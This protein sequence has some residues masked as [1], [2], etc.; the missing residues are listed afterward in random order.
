MTMKKWLIGSLI[1]LG[2]WTSQTA[3]GQ[4]FNRFLSRIGNVAL[5]QRQSIADSFMH[6]TNPLPYYE[7]DTTVIFLYQGDAQSVSMAGDATGWQPSDSFEKVEGCDLWY[8]KATYEPDARLDYKLV[9]NGSNWILDPGNPKTC[10]SG[11]GENSEL[12]MPGN[13]IPADI[14]EH[15]DIPGG[16]VSDTI[17]HSAFLG[18]SRKVSI[19]LPVGYP[20]GDIR[21]PVVLFHDGPDY[22][23][24][25]KA[26]KILDDLISKKMMAPV[27]AVFVPFVDR[28][29]EYSGK[30]K[31][32]F[33]QFI[34]KELIPALDSRLRLEPDIS[35]R[36]M[37]GASDGGN[38]SL[39]IGVK[40]PGFFGKIAVQ[41]SNVIPE[42]KETIEK[43]ALL[44]L[45]FYLDIG[46]YDIDILIPMAYNLRD[47]LNKKG[48][49]FEFREW[50]EGHSWG[51]WKEH[52]R[53]PLSFFFPY[54]TEKEKSE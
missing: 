13:M 24:I 19:Y 37:I 33:A 21:Y 14:R 32:L 36:A 35:E 43:S 7:N 15:A 49:R 46:K 48:Y 52:L 42:V 17:F 25:C 18:D 28:S 2:F 38:I 1:I 22:L 31:D 51:N 8:Y 23:N 4:N 45:F 44:P 40:Y 27:V 30:R 20:N 29:A 11:F 3:M 54:S 10:P 41:S 5:P 9:I 6:A 50:N 34:T 12:R 26:D 47:Q 39:Y 16:V 53:F